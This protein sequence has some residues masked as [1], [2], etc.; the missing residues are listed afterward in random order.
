MLIAMLSVVGIAACV[1]LMAFSRVLPRWYVWCARGVAVAFLVYFIVLG[2]DLVSYRA[3]SV[4]LLPVHR[5]VFALLYPPADYWTPLATCPI[6]QDSSN[7]RL[8]FKNKYPGAHAV[9][10]H[11]PKQDV[12]IGQCEDFRLHVRTTARSLDGP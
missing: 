4:T 9:V 10:I 2:L 11:V 6:H 7:Y 1:A 12:V 5:S 3:T 8:C